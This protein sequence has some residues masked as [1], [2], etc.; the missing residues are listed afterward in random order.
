MN[1]YELMGRPRVEWSRT[2]P[3]CRV[4]EAVAVRTAPGKLRFWYCARDCGWS[5]WRP[6]APLDCPTCGAVLMWAHSRRSV[7]CD[8]CG[9]RV[10][11]G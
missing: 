6:P 7:G 3:G 4:P 1:F 2:C 5:C 9:L 8:Q 10:R 11:A